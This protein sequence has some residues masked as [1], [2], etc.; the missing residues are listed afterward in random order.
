MPVRCMYLRH[1]TDTTKLEKRQT[2][3]SVN[4]LSPKRNP[5]ALYSIKCY[6]S[7]DI[8]ITA[9]SFLP[10]FTPTKNPAADEA[11]FLSPISNPPPTR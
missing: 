3:Q 6:I 5:A 2:T 4:Y 9:H 7:P 8:L 11:L 1:P 10:L